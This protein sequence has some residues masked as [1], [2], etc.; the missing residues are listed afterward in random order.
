MNKVIILGAGATFG[1]ASTNGS[2]QPPLLPDLYKILDADF[3]SL[4]QSVDGPIL[5]D[6]FR[7]LLEITHTKEDIERFFTLLQVIEDIRLGYNPNDLRLDP[8]KMKELY[9][10]SVFFDPLI[11]SYNLSETD[12]KDIKMILGYLVENPKRQILCCPNNFCRLFTYALN[13]YLYRSIL[14]DFCIYHDKLFADLET[15]DTVATYNYDEIAD[16]TLFL[17]G[18]LSDQ[19]FDG[20]G[21]SRITLPKEPI[22]SESVN[23]LKLHGSF[24]WHTIDLENIHYI[25]GSQNA[26]L[27]KVILPFYHKDKIYQTNKI[28]RMHMKKFGQKIHEA[29]EIIL[30]GKKFRNSDSELNRFITGCTQGPTKTIRI[31]DPKIN[32]NTFI[33]YHIKLF[34]AEFVGGWES[35]K[36]FYH[37]S[38]ST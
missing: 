28:Y 21:F 22:A 17:R 36:K 18:K 30:V 8:L 23:L 38:N 27:P 7:I 33:D 13:E 29:E 12:V 4:N 14:D 20:L 34:N 5:R 31:I 10:D 19:S 6:T 9:N 32:D 16:F 24:N 26:V 11:W 15:K 25:L 37:S 1:A 35:L 2:L 3:I